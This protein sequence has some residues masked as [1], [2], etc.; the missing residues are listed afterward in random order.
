MSYPDTLTPDFSN[1]DM[2]PGTHKLISHRWSPRAFVK[3]EISD[4]DVAVLFD[5]A[6][7]A[8]SC[9]NEQPWRFHV[10][11]DETFDDYLA[12]LN[13]SNQQWAK[14]A[15]LLGF[16]VAQKNFSHDDT[17]NAF[18][19]FDSGAAWYAMTLQARAM[20]LYTHGMGG[21]DRAGI[22]RYLQ[23]DET[24]YEVV[25]GFAIGVATGPETLPENFA[26]RET[27]SPRKPLSEI[28]FR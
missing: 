13:E 22:A 9:F 3:T 10:S 15:S 4:A 20:G 27:P 7:W 24:R 23:L 21:I 28:L 2:L 25:C 12:L 5:A 1:R 16:I 17:P 11:R 14:N 26:A 18:A 19:Q 8:P 6:R